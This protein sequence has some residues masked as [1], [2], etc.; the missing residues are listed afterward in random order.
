VLFVKTVGNQ[1]FIFSVSVYARKVWDCC[2]WKVDG[3]DIPCCDLLDW[4]WLIW[5]KNGEAGLLYL[6]KIVKSIIIESGQ[7]GLSGYPL[8]QAGRDDKRVMG[9]GI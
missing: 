3:Y 7:V 2:A 6:N 9:T 5:K 8:K 1:F 4:V